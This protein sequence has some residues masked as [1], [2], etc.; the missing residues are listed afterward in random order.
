MLRQ[1]ALPQHKVFMSG[2]WLSLGFFIYRYIVLDLILFILQSLSKFNGHILLTLMFQFELGPVKEE[3]HKFNLGEV[4]TISGS[5]LMPDWA[6]CE[7]SWYF[8]AEA[9]GEAYLLSDWEKENCNC[10]SLDD[11]RDSANSPLFFDKLFSC[12]IF[13]L[14]SPPKTM[15]SNFSFRILNSFTVIDYNCIGFFF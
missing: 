10:P 4:S 11:I 5:T 13:R 2:R 15:S 6:C 8:T 7:S 14:V 9:V 1:L 3:N 12:L